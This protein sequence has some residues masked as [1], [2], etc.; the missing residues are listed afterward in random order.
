MNKD[1]IQNIFIG[2]LLGGVILLAGGVYYLATQVQTATQGIQRIEQG[3]TEAVQ[4]ADNA[5]MKADES[6]MKVDAAMMEMEEERMQDSRI[7]VS[8]ASAEQL[9]IGRGEEELGW[10]T[11]LNFST[12]ETREYVRGDIRFTVPFN[13]A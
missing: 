11:A 1:T 5:M 8:L 3:V 10:T 13:P 9:L 4:K 2:I 12:V 7:L 6:S